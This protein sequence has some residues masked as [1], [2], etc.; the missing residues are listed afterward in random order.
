MIVL[1]VVLATIAAPVLEKGVEFLFK[2]AKEFLSG[3]RRRRRD[4][5][6]APPEVI[7]PPKE[8]SVGKTNPIAEPKDQNLEDTVADLT[9]LVGKIRDEKLDAKSPASRQAISD[10]RTIIETVLQAPITFEGEQPRTLEISDINV[11]VKEVSG[12]VAG[13]R[14]NLEKLGSA[15]IKNV[16]VDAGDV[17]EDGEVT[18]VDLT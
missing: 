1:E 14:A 6:A 15:K 2:Q 11:T 7:Q 16:K 9:E 10:L 5:K 13:V 8:I 3:W 4:S 12:R 17:K 18:G